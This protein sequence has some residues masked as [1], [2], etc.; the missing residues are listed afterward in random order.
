LGRIQPGDESPALTENAGDFAADVSAALANATTPLILCST[1]HDD[2]AVVDAAFAL[3]L[4][5]SRSDRPCRLAYYFPGANSA[6]IGMALHDEAPES[7]WDDVED[8]KIKALLILERN[9][10]AEFD[11]AADF[12]DA[13]Q[14]CELVAAIDCFENPTTT[15]SSIVIPCVSHYQAFGTL[16]N[17]EGR[18]Q[19]FSG[20]P[21]PD[22]VSHASSEILLNLLAA[23]GGSELISGSEFHDV[24]A[25]TPE[26]SQAIDALKAGE[27]GVRVRGT[28][29]PPKPNLAP[30]RHDVSGLVEWEIIHTFGSEEISA[31]SPPVQELAPSSVVELHPDEAK[32][33]N[34]SGGGE[35]DFG[36]EIG[37]KG[38]LRL[39]PG[40]AMG[41][42]GV[43][44]LRT[45]A[46]GAATCKEAQT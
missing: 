40:I 25:V 39:N 44:V 22:P 5:A 1:L 32:A 46:V 12:T 43:T 34:L 20:L 21:I 7:I 26:S 36:E 29:P 35:V 42:V 33:R 28:S 10:A 37:V 16:V 38:I 2:P 14:G 27:E 19:R 11:T 23:L 4:R 45:E 3:A 8:G 41:T 17:F 9:A 24:Y 31:L 15:A 13:I 30:A 6:G 18:A